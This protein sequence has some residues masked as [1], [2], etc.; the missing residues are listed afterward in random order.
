MYAYGTEL[1]FLAVAAVAFILN[2][3]EST[4]ILKARKR[5]KPFEKLLLSLSFADLIVATGT[6]VYCSLSL[7]GVEISGRRLQTEHFIYVLVLSED[8]SVLHILM[9]TVDRFIAVKYPIQ[10]NMRMQGKLPTIFIIA[11][12]VPVLALN[13]M[14]ILIAA[15]TVKEK[16]MLTIKIFSVTFILLGICFAVAYRHMFLVVMEQAKT[17]SA[18]YNHDSSQQCH[19]KDFLF[20]NSCRRERTMLITCCLVLSSYVICVYPVSVEVLIASGKGNISTITQ[21]LLLTN[22]ALNPLVYFFKGIR[23]RR[24]RDSRRENLLK[25]VK[26]AQTTSSPLGT[27]KSEHEDDTYKTDK[28]LIV[29]LV[30]SKI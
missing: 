16:V 3:T 7:A 12:W 24:M 17:R 6:I 18:G 25:D 11:V 26:S 5:W 27:K 10:H 21:V 22:S 4:L 15:V 1:T 2:V 9:I 20:L 28:V 8:F 19:I 29:D 14:L 13:G 23:D 30:N